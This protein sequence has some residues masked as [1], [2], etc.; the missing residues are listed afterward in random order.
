M[1]S[2]AENQWNIKRWSTAIAR[3]THRFIDNRHTHKDWYSG[4]YWVDFVFHETFL[5]LA[6]QIP[7]STCSAPVGKQYKHILLLYDL[8]LWPTALTYN[9]K[10]AK[11][12]VDSRAKDQG[13]RSN[14]SKRRRQTNKRMDRRTDRRT[15]PNV[16]SLMLRGRKNVHS[17]G[18][19]LYKTQWCH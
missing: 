3:Y 17:V 16:L 7:I 19:L 2:Q 11:V 18:D 12:K 1:D 9:P 4:V 14:S 10:L 6:C 8:E 15:L 13:H 5:Y